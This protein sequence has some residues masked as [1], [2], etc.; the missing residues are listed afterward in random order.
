VPA[1]ASRLLSQVALPPEISL[2]VVHQYEHWDGNGYPGRLTGESIPLASR[3]I[4]V[5]DELDALLSSRH[6]REPRASG[7]ALAVLGGLAGSRFDPRIVAL[8]SLLIHDGVT[9]S[10]AGKTATLADALHFLS[11]LESA[12]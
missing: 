6:D 10:L 9:E 5:A 3:I 7:D 8:A 12:R 1:A 11:T 4:A 2:A